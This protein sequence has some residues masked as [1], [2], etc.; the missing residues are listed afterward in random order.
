MS[1]SGSGN[2]DWGRHWLCCFRSVAYGRKIVHTVAHG[3]L[4]GESRN[5]AS[6]AF[7]QAFVHEASGRAGTHTRIKKP[8]KI[9]PPGPM[10]EGQPAGGVSFF[11]LSRRAIPPNHA[12][13][14]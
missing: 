3:I 10:I 12:N 14:E 8:A 7:R 6:Q 9:T 13:L 11:Q 4:S 5:A 1:R 2:I